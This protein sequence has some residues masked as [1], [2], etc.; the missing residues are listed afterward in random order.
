MAYPVTTVTLQKWTDDIDTKLL[1]LQSITTNAK[2]RSSAGQLNM[3][4]IRRYFDFLVNINNFLLAAVAVS[5]L[6]AFLDTAK[7][8]TVP[9]AVAAITAIQ[10]QIIATL[11]WLR[12][13]VPEGA[14]GGSQYKLSFAFPTNNT[15]ESVPLTFT[16]AQTSDFRTALDGLL[17]TMS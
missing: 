6:P 12:A 1:S 4:D 5:G 10:N 14:F 11:D 17:G 3:D 9:D 7:G 2:T 8:G 16:A 13:N 15:S